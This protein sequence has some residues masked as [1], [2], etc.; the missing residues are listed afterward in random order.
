[1]LESKLR[2]LLDRFKQQTEEVKHLR[3]SDSLLKKKLQ[4]MS[5]NQSEALSAE[6]VAEE[7]AKWIEESKKEVRSV[8][9]K[10]ETGFS[11]KL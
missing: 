3:E 6:Q 8:T 4:E 7:K 5:V 11:N 10:I 2:A 1:M 9:W